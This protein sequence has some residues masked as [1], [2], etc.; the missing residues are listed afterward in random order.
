MISK[1]IFIRLQYNLHHQCLLIS[2]SYNM[3]GY[4]YDHIRCG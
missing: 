1:L 3:F 4:A 2:C